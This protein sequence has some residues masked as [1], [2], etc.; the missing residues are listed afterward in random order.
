M[1]FLVF[2]VVQWY[3]IDPTYN[4]NNPLIIIQSTAWLFNKDDWVVSGT[5]D[6]IVTCHSVIHYDWDLSY[7]YIVYVMNDSV[8]VSGRCTG[9][10][11]TINITGRLTVVTCARRHHHHHG[12]S[13]SGRH[14]SSL[15]FYILFFSVFGNPW[16]R[17]HSVWSALIKMSVHHPLL[18]EYSRVHQINFVTS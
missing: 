9:E 8:T 6:W 2:A 4:I 7:M 5:V 17:A 10:I 18:A 15:Y 16:T 14:N 12:E 13:S 1:D 11:W 3:Y